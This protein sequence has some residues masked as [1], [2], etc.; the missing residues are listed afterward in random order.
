MVAL[1]ASFAG[2]GCVPA[3]PYQLG[4]SIRMTLELDQPP[5]EQVCVQV[6]CEH[7]TQNAQG[8]RVQKV[9]FAPR[10]QQVSQQF[11]LDDSLE[12]PRSAAKAT[13]QIVAGRGYEV[14]GRDQ[15][16]LP[17]ASPAE[18]AFADDW[19]TPT[20]GANGY[21][22]NDEVEIALSLSQAAPRERGTAVTLSSSA[23][24]RTGATIASGQKSLKLRVKL[25]HAEPEEQSVELSV[26]AGCNLKPKPTRSLRVS[27][28]PKLSF[29]ANDPL[30][31]PGP[32]DVLS[33]VSLAIELDA[34][35]VRE[36]KA[37]LES[38]LFGDGQEERLNITIAAGQ[39]KP[40][41][42]VAIQLRRAFADASGAPE[43]RLIKLHPVSG[44]AAG[45]TTELR[46]EVV[47]SRVIEAQF[48]KTSVEQKLPVDS[49]EPL[50]AGDPVKVTVE[51]SERVAT[52][53]KVRISS[54]ELAKKMGERSCTL[55]F[56][57][58]TKLAF[59]QL[60]L[61]PACIQGS[62]ARKVKLSLEAVS[63]CTLGKRTELSLEVYPLPTASFPT[64]WI[65]PVGATKTG[66]YDEGD[67]VVLTV[68]LSQAAPLTTV[69]GL[70]VVS[71]ALAAPLPVPFD[72][73]S[74]EAFVRATLVK[75]SEALQDVKLE[76]LGFKKAGVNAFSVGSK[77][78]EHTRQIHV[79]SVPAVRFAPT[80]VV[81]RLDPHEEGTQLSFNLR[82]QHSAERPATFLLRS[83]AFPGKVVEV[84]IPKGA[85]RPSSSV[86]VTLT[87]GYLDA[88]GNCIAQAVRIVP[89]SGCKAGYP[90]VTKVRVTGIKQT[91]PND[92][93][94]PC[95]ETGEPAKGFDTQCNTYGLKLV[96]THGDDAE[97]AD[98][99]EDPLALVTSPSVDWAKQ[100]QA[101]SPRMALRLQLIAGNTEEDDEKQFHLTWLRLHLPTK[102]KYCEERFLCD[103]ETELRHPRIELWRE[104]DGAWISQLEK[105]DDKPDTDPA[106]AYLRAGQEGVV[107][108]MPIRP[109]KL[110]LELTKKQKALAAIRKKIKAAIKNVVKLPA[111]ALYEA[112]QAHR[113]VVPPVRYR[114]TVQTCGIPFDNAPPAR[115]LQLPIEVFPSDE[116]ALQ[117]KVAPI[118]G[119]SIGSDGDKLDED[120]ETKE[121]DAIQEAL[122]ELGLVDEDD[123]DEPTGGDDGE[124]EL[125]FE[126]DA[127]SAAGTSAPAPDQIAALLD[128]G[129]RPTRRLDDQPAQRVF[130][131]DVDTKDDDNKG[132]GWTGGLIPAF[133]VTISKN[134]K[135]LGAK[136]AEQQGK[137][138]E[139]E[140]GEGAS[141][142]G[143]LMSPSDAVTTV[144]QATRDQIDSKLA[145]LSTSFNTALSAIQIITSVLNNLQ[146]MVPSFGF[147]LKLS[148]GFLEGT[149]S[150]RWG[151]KEYESHEV[152]LW[153]R[154][155]LDMTLFRIAFELRFGISAGLLCI[156]FEAVIFL[157]LA[158][159]LRFEV[160]REI[161]GPKLG[162]RQDPA[163]M[164]V[165]TE[166][167]LGLRVVLIHEGLFSSEGKIV[168]GYK[169]GFRIAKRDGFALEYEAYSLGVKAV[170]QVK[171]IGFTFN[172]ERQL[173]SGSELPARR[174][175]LFPRGGNDSYY[176]LRARVKH[177][178]SRALAAYKPLES[179]VHEWHALQLK[180]VNLLDPEMTRQ[181]LRQT[182]ASYDEAVKSNPDA[183]PDDLGW[184]LTDFPGVAISHNAPRLRSRESSQWRRQWAL[185][186]QG[187]C[188][189]EAR[190]KKRRGFS[191][192]T[193]GTRFDK[194]LRGDGKG[195]RRK[196][197]LTHFVDSVVKTAL[198]TVH[199]EF[200]ALR[201]LDKE[202]DAVEDFD[203][204]WREPPSSLPARVAKLKQDIEAAEH[205]GAGMIARIKETVRATL[206]GGNSK[207]RDAFKR[208]VPLDQQ[209]FRLRLDTASHYTRIL[210]ATLDKQ[211]DAVPAA[212]K[213]YAKKHAKLVSERND[214]LA[215]AVAA[216][217]KAIQKAQRE[218]DKT[219]EA[220]QKRH[221]KKTRK[222][223]DPAYLA[224]RNGK[225]R[226]RTLAADNKFALAKRQAQTA[227]DR[228]CI[229][230]KNRYALDEQK[231]YDK[232]RFAYWRLP[233]TPPPK[234][235][236]KIR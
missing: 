79:F 155:D 196:P 177:L 85:S 217:D 141:G 20:P 215:K 93:A 31:P 94:Q 135:P 47:D 36:C 99:G 15:L 181:L 138:D 98:R 173:V 73:G 129:T 38:E 225:L 49:F 92:P 40:S 134:G 180:L 211:K 149:L 122:D 35:A 33:K 10:T 145:K 32:V 83:T 108:A 45:E 184:P 30:T 86:S 59:A 119:Y 117:L 189:I 175:I 46:L 42:P 194:H 199:Q 218:R 179:A 100:F 123:D 34:P 124:A 77:D 169:W 6:R 192:T 209:L 68:Q 150:Y 128:K 230:A 87:K 23:F 105:Q 139:N 203:S 152:F 201:A 89:I 51:L 55:T 11:V 222:N 165:V 191:T 212:K 229:E 5:T 125:E 53:A 50:T 148:L 195:S 26:G 164:W 96:E 206:I 205:S 41:K 29:A 234:R 116:Y 156:K 231:L 233:Q 228:T 186:E 4:E 132:S 110:K 182:K 126:D 207:F 204:G 75:P 147:S 17:L 22:E 90:I 136:K 197:G 144:W 37:R 61:D 9:M 14:G 178:W 21:L 161:A 115:Q 232:M 62:K 168:G 187:L 76:T 114:L 208:K 140:E 69:S 146:D 72:P 64:R 171:V 109:D 216:R 200:D 80:A 28:A 19:I 158:A 44:C 183:S 154:L 63:G 213:K 95:P 120:G 236:I 170:I 113:G 188:G 104:H 7:F 163:W 78:D 210:E 226:E 54:P 193:F 118:D 133:G 130:Y 102:D 121:Q 227:Y 88:R 1:K 27:A 70:R 142:K 190:V 2:D 162:W 39:T 172:K 176:G 57:P 131:P 106:T 16:E 214:K 101:G 185:C 112:L 111:F 153:K 127:I 107:L 137:Q 58:G 174:G 219:V 198:E 82:L 48:P 143:G 159:K 81:E 65:S 67:E 224:R 56:A 91:D 157:R 13:A 25:T 71:S 103:D 84:T 235:L 202:I 97:E 18:L 151:F 223:K 166:A 220:E 167:A 3:P 66:P 8:E 12:P 221:A 160:A 52:G 74:L 60:E 43:A 24:S